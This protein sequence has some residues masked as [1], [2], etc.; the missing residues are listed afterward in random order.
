MRCG[1][2]SRSLET[3]TRTSRANTHNCNGIN[4]IPIGVADVGVI[5][6]RLKSGVQ[7]ES[8]RR[9]C[10]LKSGWPD[11]FSREAVRRDRRTT[12]SLRGRELQ[13]EEQVELI[14][15]DGS[16]RGER[17]FIIYNPPVTDHAL[18]LR[19]SSLLESVRLANDLFI[20]NVQSVVFACARAVIVLVCS[21]SA[22]EPFCS[23]PLVALQHVHV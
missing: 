12:S 21:V 8:E 4:I 17:R 5:R 1:S 9:G 23:S 11:Y 3:K 7:G 19:K 13:L 10:G 16:S 15:N 6:G 22:C 2:R 18:G 14:D 20:H